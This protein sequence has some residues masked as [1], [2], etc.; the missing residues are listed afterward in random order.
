MPNEYPVLTREEV[1]YEGPLDFEDLYQ[2]LYRWFELHQYKL[3]EKKFKDKPKPA[4]P[5]QREI[6]IDWVAEKDIDDYTKFRYNIA[7]RI[8]N[9]KEITVK[10]DGENKKM[11]FAEIRIWVSSTIVLDKDDKWE[12]SV[13]L[14][15]L[16]K[17]FEAYIYKSTR[18]K[19]EEILLKESQGFYNEAKA[20]LNLNKV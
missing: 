1:R 11:W 14:H 7:F 19:L 10:K 3:E 18:K 8:I 6:E 17:F 12:E 4:A 15:F 16:K 9:V 2:R 20:L 13:F 5:I